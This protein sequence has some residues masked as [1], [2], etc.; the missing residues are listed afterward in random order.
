MLPP[1]GKI[2]SRNRKAVKP[3]GY[4]ALTDK[5][6]GSNDRRDGD[7]KRDRGKG[8]GETRGLCAGGKGDPGETGRGYPGI[9]L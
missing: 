3:P 8:E 5:K 1:V 6:A 7:L 4:S 9:I 2:I